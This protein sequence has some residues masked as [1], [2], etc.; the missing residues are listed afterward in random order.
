MLKDQLT[1]QQKEQA[2]RTK[3]EAPLEHH[4]LHPLKRNTKEAGKE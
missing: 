2:K 1:S 4:S 3:Q